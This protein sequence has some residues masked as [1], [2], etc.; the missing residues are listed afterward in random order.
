MKVPPYL[1]GGNTVSKN[2]GT[3]KISKMLLA[4][5]IYKPTVNP[6]AIS[7]R[8]LSRWLQRYR[9]SYATD[10]RRCERIRL[11]LK[12]LSLNAVVF[13]SEHGPLKECF[14]TT[15]TTFR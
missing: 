2:V 9:I 7:A 11:F 4:R 3:N 6:L 13:H 8:Y 12:V 15:P 10:Y 1:T 14:K 5:S